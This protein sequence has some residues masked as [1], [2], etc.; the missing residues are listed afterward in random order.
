M[1]FDS[2]GQLWAMDGHGAF[3][4]SAYAICFVVLGLV[5]RGSMARRSRLL[6]RV[7]SRI[8]TSARE[9]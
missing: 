6:Q 3:V 1:Y 9:G 7:R 2:F 5:V 8:D 4:W